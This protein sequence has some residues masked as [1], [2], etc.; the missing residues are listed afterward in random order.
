MVHFSSGGVEGGGGPQDQLVK[1]MGG[2][3][4]QLLCLFSVSLCR[5]SGCRLHQLL[6]IL[7][8]LRPPVTARA[9]GVGGQENMTPIYFFI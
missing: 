5:L 9:G 3:V 8:F 4:F 6:G 2:V 1:I 7:R